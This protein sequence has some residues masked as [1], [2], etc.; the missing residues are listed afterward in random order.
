VVEIGKCCW[1]H[2]LAG[3]TVTIHEHLDQSV[4]IRFGPHVVGSYPEGSGKDGSHRLA[5]DFPSL[6]Q[7]KGEEGSMKSRPDN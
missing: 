5:Y 2:T 7:I 6:S 3:Q 1:R 4:S